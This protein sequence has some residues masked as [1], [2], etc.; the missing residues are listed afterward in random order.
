M[1]MTKDDK[2]SCDRE[3]KVL[4]IDKVAMA[5][6]AE[7]ITALRTLVLA[8]GTIPIEGGRIWA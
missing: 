7:R 1:Y 5:S 8:R 4:R 6:M 2:S 3:Y